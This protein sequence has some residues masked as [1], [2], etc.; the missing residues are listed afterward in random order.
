MLKINEL[1]SLIANVDRAKVPATR[2][3][4]MRAAYAAGLRDMRDAAATKLESEHAMLSS[5][6]A[7]AIVRATLVRNGDYEA[8][9]LSQRA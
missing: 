5:V 1:D 2:F 9:F 6:R 8:F 7:G 4:Y 3:D